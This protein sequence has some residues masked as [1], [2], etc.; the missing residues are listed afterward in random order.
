MAVGGSELPPALEAFLTA[1][2]TLDELLELGY[3]RGSGEVAR[4]LR[5]ATATD[6]ERQ[7]P[8]FGAFAAALFAKASS[9][10]QCRQC[11]NVA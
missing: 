2:R 9:C 3:Y 5:A 8:A 10:A 1:E 7:G 4:Q 6:G 11:A